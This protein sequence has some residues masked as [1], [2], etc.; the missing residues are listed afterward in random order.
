MNQHVVVEICWT[1]RSKNRY[2]YGSSLSYRSTYYA[3][4]LKSCCTVHYGTPLHRLPKRG[5]LTPPKV[6]IVK[7]CWRAAYPDGKKGTTYTHVRFLETV[8]TLRNTAV[9]IGK[10]KQNVE[11]PDKNRVLFNLRA[12]QNRRFYYPLSKLRGF[13]RL[14]HIFSNRSRIVHR[15]LPESAQNTVF[16]NRQSGVF[17]VTRRHYTDNL[18]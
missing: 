14:S 18:R 9:L 15:E 4:F 6:C 3:V 2:Q 12:Y 16:S 10:S 11:N 1:Q 5:L 8:K 7:V 17:T 13:L